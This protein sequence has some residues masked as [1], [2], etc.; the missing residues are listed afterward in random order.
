MMAISMWLCPST[1]TQVEL[2][3]GAYVSQGLQPREIIPVF[4]GGL[5]M[6]GGLTLAGLFRTPPDKS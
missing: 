2:L 6:M 4:D 1:Q 5:D 3:I